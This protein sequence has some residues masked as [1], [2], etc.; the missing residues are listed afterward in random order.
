MRRIVSIKMG[1]ITFISACRIT[2]KGWPKAF[3]QPARFRRPRPWPAP[4]GMASIRRHSSTR[5]VRLII[6]GASSTCRGARLRPD[7]KGIEPGSLHSHLLT[8]E[9]HGFH[10]GASI[11]KHGGLYYLVYTDISRGRATC[12]AYATA[13]SPLGPFEKRGILIDNTG[14]DPQTWN[15][16]GSIA[17]FNG[18]WYVFYHR[19]SQA[20]KFNRRVCVEPIRFNL[21]GSIDEVE[22]TTQGVSDPLPAT[23]NIEAWRA[24]LLS[25]QVYTESMQPGANC[26]SYSE[27]LTM[28]HD[29]D[30]AAYKYVDFGHGVSGF[31]AQAGSLAYGGAIE[32]HLDRPDGALVGTCQ[33]TGSGGWQQWKKAACSVQGAAGVHALYLVFRG[34]PGRLF[35]LEGFSFLGV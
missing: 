16:H 18:Q 3:C 13:Q 5:M 21:D 9:K 34:R 1:V 31:Q 7:L 33:V 20:S 22:M 11:R 23:K 17:A 15:N 35:N 19:S 32:L 29:G 4:T 26:L 24:C 25:G 6:T 28:I 12:L 2:A 27:H 10:E 14:C 8:E 30:W